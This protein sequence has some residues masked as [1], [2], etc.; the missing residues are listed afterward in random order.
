M[1]NNYEV[2]IKTVG[3]FHG[4]VGRGCDWKRGTQEASKVLGK[5]SF[6]RC[7]LCPGVGFLKMNIL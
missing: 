4:L 7:V 1:W 3:P 2:R 5:Y 6:T